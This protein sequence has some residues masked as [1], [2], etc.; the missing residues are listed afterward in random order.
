MYFD[1]LWSQY[2]ST[3]VHS[4]QPIFEWLSWSDWRRKHS[5]SDSNK[6]STSTLEGI[7]TT[8]LRNYIFRLEFASSP[9][10]RYR[11][12]F[13]YSTTLSTKQLCILKNPWIEDYAD[14]QRP[15]M[16]WKDDHIW[17]SYVCTLAFIKIKTC[18]ETVK[19]KR[20]VGGPKEKISAKRREPDEP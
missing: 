17:R 4:L 12:Y 3:E 13:M 15:T 10:P 20:P 5:E 18:S 16:R 1:K 9:H 11:E 6:D 19:C 8:A 2:W 7:E 14:A